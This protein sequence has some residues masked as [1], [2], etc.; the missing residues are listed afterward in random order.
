M[1]QLQ[2]VT[3][4]L[5]ALDTAAA[6][7]PHNTRSRTRYCDV[8]AQ[9]VNIEGYCF[10]PRVPPHINFACGKN[11]TYLNMVLHMVLH[12]VLPG[13]FVRQAWARRRAFLRNRPEHV[14]D[15]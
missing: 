14:R 9:H 15:A 13:A 3:T 7:V 4:Q 8:H 6:T 11:L 10:P 5:N 1:A 2:S 12:M